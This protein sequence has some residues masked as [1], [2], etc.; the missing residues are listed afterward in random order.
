MV[1]RGGIHILQ[2]VEDLQ[3]FTLAVS[4]V[5]IS[6]KTGEFRQLIWK[7]WFRG[8]GGGVQEFALLR[9]ARLMLPAY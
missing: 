5:N 6:D 9:F 4:S 8:A 1:L 3:K 2:A 7:G